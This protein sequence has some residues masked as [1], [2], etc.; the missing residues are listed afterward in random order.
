[1]LD[2]AIRLE[3]EQIGSLL[4]KMPTGPCHA[5]KDRA[6]LY[7]TRAIIHDSHDNA[8][9]LQVVTLLAERARCEPSFVNDAKKLLRRM[10]NP[11]QGRVCGS[12]AARAESV[13]GGASKQLLLNSGIASGGLPNPAR[14]VTGNCR[15]LRLIL[16]NVPLPTG[17]RRAGGC[18]LTGN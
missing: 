2:E 16:A 17:R 11:S 9:R 4:L 12:S 15:N 6:E 10:V 13:G 14:V 5:L 3:P 1:M 7:L 18:G 8:S